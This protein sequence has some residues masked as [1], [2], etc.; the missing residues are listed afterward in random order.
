MRAER[1]IKDVHPQPAVERYV[2]AAGAG[3]GYVCVA[4][5]GGI[6]RSPD[7]DGRCGSR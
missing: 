5:A 1:F 3:G 7:C 2:C 6:H 4:K